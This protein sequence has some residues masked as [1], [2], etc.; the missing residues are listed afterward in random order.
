MKA[1][2][3]SKSENA[4]SAKYDPLSIEPKWQAKWQQEKVYQ[5]ELSNAKNRFYNLMMFPYPS[6]EGLHV[7]NMY[8]FTGA[9]IYGRFQ[10]MQGKAVFEPIGLDGFGIHS[11]NYSLKVG[12]HP[13][14]QAAISETNFYRQ[15]TTIGNGFAWDNRVETYKPEY[16]RWTQWTFTQLFKA[17]LAYREKS[18]VNFCPSCKTVLADEQVEDGKCE[19]CGTVVEKRD[20]EQWFF[21]ITEYAEQLLQGLE[22][23]D[24]TEK[25]KI[26]QR[27]WIGKSEGA[28]IRFRIVDTKIDLSV[29][30]TRPDT[31]HGA[32]FM[33][34]SPEHPVVEHWLDNPGVKDYVT[35]AKNKAEAERTAAEKEKTGVFSGAYALNPA[36]NEQ[37]PIWIAD[38]V[39]MSYGTG[40]IMAVPAHDERDFA[41]AKKYDLPIRQVIAPETGKARKDEE[42]RD[43]GSAVIFDPK[44]QKYAVADYP[45]GVYRLYGG[46][47]DEGEGLEQAITRE[48]NEESGLFDFGHKEQ[49]Q[50][51]FAHYYNDRKH[52]SRS[53][54]ATSFLFILNTTE[55][56]ERHLEPHEVGM[57][58]VWKTPEEILANWSEH[59]TEGSLDHWIDSLKRSVARTIELGVD[60]TST[61]DGY[62]SEAF[63]GYDGILVNSGEWDGLGVAEAKKAAVKALE[64]KEV[65]N[66]YTNY[67]LRDWLISRQRYWGPPIPMI[68]CEAC[69][70]EGKSWFTS[71]QRGPVGGF[72]P[73]SAPSTSSQVRA[74]GSPS[75]SA[76][77]SRHIANLKLK[78]ENSSHEMAG[79]YPVPDEDLPVLLPRI[80]DYK[81]LGTGKSPLARHP[82]FYEVT[83][84]GC[85]GKATRETDVSD[86]FLDSSWY[87]LRYLA[88]DLQEIPF[89]MSADCFPQAPQAEKAEAAER[90][91]WLPVNMYIGGAEHA[92]L[93]LLYTRFFYKVFGDLGF[94][95]AKG[96]S[97]SGRD[98]A[99]DEPFPRFY[100]HG[101]IIKD[102]AKMSKSKGNV[103]VPD[104]YIRKFGADTLRTY[105]MFIGPFSGGGDFSDSGIEGINRFLKRVWTLFTTQ[106]ISST[107]LD[108]SAKSWLHQTVKGVTEDMEGL[109]YNTA[110]AKIM[111][112]YNFLSKKGSLQQEEADVFLKLLAPFAP[113]MTEEL[114]QRTKNKDQKAFASIHV[115]AWPEFDEAAI[116]ADEVVIAVQVNGK[117]RDTLKLSSAKSQAQSEIEEE[118]RTR[119]NVKKHLEG[120]TVK[121][122]VYVPGK[123]LNFVVAD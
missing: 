19:R 39:L 120:K 70:K 43:G 71:H 6:A 64:G 106:T 97:S 13:M 4:E 67:H 72:P 5:P 112:Y 56:K 119:E 66:G 82:D 42:R 50:T 117:L 32:T 104:E 41:F 37:I 94:V 54:L 1:S 84:P 114:Y 93:H 73:A 115:S 121:K 60:T 52:L 98:Q 16:Y 3:K 34:V 31:L 24:W 102:G 78:I 8:A 75:T 22:T 63:T 11:E 79:W 49:I 9:D 26:A 90:V 89:P 123:I 27:N 7:G 76:T 46:G 61:K 62:R 77:P 21:R 95:S 122:V 28:R 48:V 105:L 80:E 109:R 57:S 81:P 18:P 83:C 51:Y 113:H 25:V 68:Y 47:S 85:G 2:Q 20:L 55:E 88:T 45:D 58:L 87:F 101:L 38:Y 99:N 36:T 92:V 69:A 96:R 103:V 10:R 100:A 53:A 65:G 12:R 17:G 33:V 29:F 40:A 108:A 86:T 14:D 111:T 116:Q 74:V 30:T 35:A 23:I 15:L 44:T 118:A 107:P 91:S 59:N 110:I